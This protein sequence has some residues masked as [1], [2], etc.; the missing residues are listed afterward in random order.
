MRNLAVRWLKPDRRPALVLDAVRDAE[1]NGFRF[2]EAAGPQP[3]IWF[4]RVAGGTV[5]GCRIP[6][7]V[8][9]FLRVTGPE[10][11]NIAILSNDL[12]LP[13][14]VIDIGSGAEHGAVGLAGNLTPG[15]LPV[16]D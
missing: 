16:I 9:L 5:T 4:H 15:R 14:R 7:E 13:K 11:R 8:A 10:T 6:R 3:V 12:R 2:D 1:L